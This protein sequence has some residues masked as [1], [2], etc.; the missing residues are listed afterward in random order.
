M[1]SGL[2]IR[3]PVEVSGF[4]LKNM[5][6][7]AGDGVRVAPLILAREPV[8]PGAGLADRGLGFWDRSISAVGVATMLAVVTAIGI[9]FL[10]VGRG[11]RRRLESTDLD[12]ALSGVEP[13]SVA[14]SLRRVAA[15]EVAGD[16][17][18]RGGA[19]T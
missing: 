7:R 6:Y 8:R 9:A 19:N 16:D 10:I 5:A 18:P 1:V 3:E 4:F 14:D 12:V 15:D 13:F 17:D 11:R 2:D